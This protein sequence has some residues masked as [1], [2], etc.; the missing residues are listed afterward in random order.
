LNE[1]IVAGEE[2][3]KNEDRDVMYGDNFEEMRKEV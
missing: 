2:N 3:P 1:L